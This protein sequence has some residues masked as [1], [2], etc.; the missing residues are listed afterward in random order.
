MSPSRF[1]TVNPATVQ[2]LHKIPIAVVDN[3]LSQR[4]LKAASRHLPRSTSLHP[5]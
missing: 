4:Q 5:M 2:I 3:D 1:S